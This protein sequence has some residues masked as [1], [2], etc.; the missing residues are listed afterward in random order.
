MTEATADR[1]EL[2]PEPAPGRR[3]SWVPWLA[4]AA[5]VVAI[6]AVWAR[7][8]ALGVSLWWDEAYSARQFIPFGPTKIIDPLYYLPNDHILFNLL[9]WATTAIVGTTEAILRFWSVVPALAAGGVIGW[10]G[11]R[12]HG[13]VVGV[14]A[15]LFIVTS[16]VHLGLSVQARGYGLGF[17]AAALMLVGAVAMEWRSID[18][19]SFAPA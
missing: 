16:P 18:S 13:P 4:A 7:W 2:T 9:A 8:P 1:V 5:A 17:L 19:T 3:R 11:W 14:A 15:A 12:R 6:A 10:W